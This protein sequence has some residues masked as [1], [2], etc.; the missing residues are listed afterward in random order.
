[1]KDQNSYFSWGRVV[2]VCMITACTELMWTLYN[3]YVP[4]WLQAGNPA[5]DLGPEAV[6]IVGFGL[7][8]FVT[9]VILTVDN[10][11]GLFISPVIGLLSDTTNTRFGRRKPWIIFTMPIMIIAFI[12]IPVF[13]MDIPIELSGQTAELTKYLVPFVIV[14]GVMLLAYAVIRAPADVIMYD[15]TPSKHRSMASAI[16]NFIGAGFGV[17]GAI[18]GAMLFDISPGLPFWVGAGLSGLIISLVAWRITEPKLE[19]LR[20]EANKKLSPKDTIKELRSLPKDSL[21]S[22]TFLFL[23]VFFSYLAFGQ[24]GSFASSYGVFVLKM[25]VGSSGMLYAAGGAAFILGTLPTGFI[26]KKITRKQASLIGY[27]AFSIMGLVIYLFPVPMVAWIALAI[28]GLL[29]ALVWV[30]QVPMVMDAVPNDR[31]LGSLEGV[32]AIC[33]MLGYIIGPMIG[34]FV[35]EK[36]GNN[37]SNIWLVVMVG[38]ILGAL[39]LL[40]V[41]KGEVREVAEAAS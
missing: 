28:G 14:L 25:D 32:L 2:L 37:Y 33:R 1:M 30:P 23:S 6:G 31:V 10:I 22:L 9:G 24:L 41:T 19:E 39:M 18:I 16:A 12:L 13:V 35:V 15:I 27:A 20:P 7:G 4:I 8:A 40:P 34:G 17:I 36:F 38:G 3:T 11:A 21:K 5:F 29:W 26:L